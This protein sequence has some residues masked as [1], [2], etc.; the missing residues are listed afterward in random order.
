VFAWGATGGWSELDRDRLE[1]SPLVTVTLT[2]V[3][4]RT[5]MSVRVELPAHLSEDRVQEWWSIGIRDGWRQTV[6]RLAAALESMPTTV[7]ARA[8][9]ASGATGPTATELQKTLRE[10]QPAE[11]PWASAM[12]PSTPARSPRP[13]RTTKS[14]I[15]SFSS[16]AST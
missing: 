15:A 8:S 3:R 10:A 9:L 6:D 5:E 1:D 16:G 12:A 13:G 2:E 4:E 11:G 7:L 14:P